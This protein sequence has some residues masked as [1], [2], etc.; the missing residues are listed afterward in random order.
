[1]ARNVTQHFY[2]A[3]HGELLDV[4]EKLHP[5]SAHGVAANAYEL[6]RGMSRAKFLRDCCR[7]EVAG[8][9]AGDE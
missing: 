8:R 6:V 7:M 3:H 2:E 1:V 5:G 9:L 4:M